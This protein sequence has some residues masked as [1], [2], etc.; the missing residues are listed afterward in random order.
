M[1]QWLKTSKTLEG[2]SNDV[3]KEWKTIA[4][5]SKFLI[6]GSILRMKIEMTKV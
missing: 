1:Y 4:R 2:A 5:D 6:E 3:K